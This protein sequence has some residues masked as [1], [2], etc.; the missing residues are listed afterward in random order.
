MKLLIVE[1]PA[2]AKT[3]S[4]YYRAP[5]EERK[6][7]LACEDCL[8]IQ[9]PRNNDFTHSV[10]SMRSIPECCF[11]CG[12][13]AIVSLKSIVERGNNPPPAS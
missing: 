2:K 12:E 5:E 1:S 8:T 6:H 9:D 13:D 3:I 4:K 11:D 10:E 7:M